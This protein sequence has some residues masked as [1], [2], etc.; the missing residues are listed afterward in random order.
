M[1]YRKVIVSGYYDFENEIYLQNQAWDN[2]PGYRV[3]TPLVLEK[4][5]D[6]IFI[7]R[8]WIGLDDLDQIE[9]INQEYDQLQVIKGIIRKSQTGNDFG[10]KSNNEG[11]TSTGFHLFIDLDIIQSGLDYEIYPIYVQLDGENNYQKPY[12]ELSEIEITGGPHFGYAIQWFFFAGL[13]GFGYP[14]FV[15]KQMNDLR[16]R[17]REI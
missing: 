17:S 6:V 3:V 11:R 16:I 10:I 7:D 5:S 2:L 9:L 13:L 14:F 15:R 12:S 1:E 8:G 4:S